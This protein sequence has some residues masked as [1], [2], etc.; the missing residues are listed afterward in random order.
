MQ[1]GPSELDIIFGR[2]ILAF[3]MVT[4]QQLDESLSIQLQLQQAQQPK[5]LAQIV[6]KKGFLNQEQYQQIVLEIR[7]RFGPQMGATAP[8]NPQDSKS[9]QSLVPPDISVTGS[10]VGARPSPAIPPPPPTMPSPLSV[11]P[12]PIS[13]MSGMPPALAGMPAPMRPGVATKS[14]GPDI[15]SAAD[16]WESASQNRSEGGWELV[17]DSEPETA[18]PLPA[19]LDST[20]KKK[21]SKDGNIRKMLNVPEHAE[22]FAIGSY[23]VLEAVA[24]GGMGVIYRAQNKEGAIHALKAL[25][26]VE[27]AS[28]KQLKRFREEGRLMS[29]FDHPH[30]VKVYEMDVF[31]GVPYFTMDFLV[32]DDLHALLKARKAT[33]RANVTLLRKVCEAVGHAHSKG[34][35]HRDL[36]P[37]NIFV[38]EDGEPILTDFGLAK[39]LESEFKLTAEGAMVGTPLYLSPEQ[40]AGQAHK[41]D[42]RVDI[43]G[44]GVILY[45]ICTGRLPFVGKNPYE[46][47][48]KV[49][50]EDPRTPRDINPKLA[51][52][53]EKII[54]T[55]MAKRPEDRFETAEDMASDLRA[56][57][58]GQ[59]V[60]CVP[61]PPGRRFKRKKNK[62]APPPP[63][64][65]SPTDETQEEPRDQPREEIPKRLTRSRSRSKKPPIVAIVAAVVI[66]GGAVAY[67]CYALL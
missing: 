52:D 63:N 28:E 17:S 10:Y 5:T 24:A 44:L 50:S 32:G 19:L 51:E 40:V 59:P 45:Q 9:V 12:P 26:N 6:V 47:Y 54:L 21:K 30:I 65:V 11:R 23:T 3:R 41:A 29:R 56:W 18:R 7:R 2:A 61:P 1:T 43:Y 38:R 14:P 25:M 49:L 15:R 58:N 39:N 20:R 37:S 64:P 46:V 36:K 35:I 33:I 42:G 62:K 66:I 27:K 22:Q 55:A 67:A 8:S 16:R 13:S 57:C 4:K 34:V 48:K 53:L 31:Q 60:K